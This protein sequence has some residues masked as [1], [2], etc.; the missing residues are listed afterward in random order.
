MVAIKCVI[1]YIMSKSVH[2]FHGLVGLQNCMDILESEPGSCT[3]TCQVS[4]DDGNL[5]VGIKVE[6]VTDIEVE[7][8]PGSAI[9]TGIKAEHA[10]SLSVCFQ[11]YVRWTN[12]L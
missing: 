10:V 3:G 1:P 8:D 9:S 6:G 4:S 7:E 11:G 2:N 5:V 12:C